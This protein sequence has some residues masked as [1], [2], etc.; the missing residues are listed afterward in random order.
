MC[1]MQCGDFL[2]RGKVFVLLLDFFVFIQYNTQE[3][4]C[5]L[6]KFLAI[7]EVYAHVTKHSI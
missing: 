4:M 7:C 2:S 3:F 1:F 5:I 6:N